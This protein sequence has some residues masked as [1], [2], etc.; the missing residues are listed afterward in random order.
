MLIDDLVTKGTSE[1]YRLLTSR[2]EYRLLL[3]HDNADMRLL[4]KAYTI[5]MIE[6]E[7]YDKFVIKRQ[8]VAEEIER[9]RTV[10]V[11]PNEATQAAIQAAGGTAL[12]D[13]IRGSDL[14]KRPEMH[15]DVVASLIPKPA[16][17]ELS[18]E[19]KEQIEIQLKY[20][21]YITKALGEVEKLHKME[22][23]KIPENIDYDAISGLAT[24]A[25]QHLKEV[26]PLTLAQASRISGVNPADI[27]ILLVYL[28][29][30]KIA[31][32]QAE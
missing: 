18:E 31:K 26:M 27:S 19:V 11:K 16:H 28:E 7:R 24:E 17:A 4:E 20:E 23:K 29:Q 13:G 5:G 8:Q 3:R 2:A 15:Y 14:L 25:R 32:V 22:G 30:G 6:Q 21:G 9:L 10:F 12:R 1:P